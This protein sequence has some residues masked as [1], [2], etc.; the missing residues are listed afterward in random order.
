MTETATTLI[1]KID[2]KKLR[3][4]VKNIDE[5]QDKIGRCTDMKTYNKIDYEGT[6]TI[7]KRYLASK[8][9]NGS[10]KIKYDF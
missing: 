4:I 7:L 6:K 9:T 3:C 1:E 8:D 2:L 10:S 5:L